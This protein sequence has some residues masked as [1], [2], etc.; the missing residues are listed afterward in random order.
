MTRIIQITYRGTVYCLS[1]ENLG[2]LVLLLAL[3]HNNQRKT[4]P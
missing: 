4:K 1:L 3:N 2:R